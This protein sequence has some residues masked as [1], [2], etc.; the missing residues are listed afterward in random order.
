MYGYTPYAG[1]KEADR[2][3]KKRK[4]LLNLPA[5]IE[6]CR[7]EYPFWLSAG[8]PLRPY[9][10]LRVELSPEH[11]RYFNEQS[12]DWGKLCHQWE[13]R[14]SERSFLRIWHPRGNKESQ[15]PVVDMD[16]TVIQFPEPFVMFPFSLFFYLFFFSIMISMG[17][18]INGKKNKNG[19]E[20]IF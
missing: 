18:W 11:P 13:S 19:F 17:R 3:H 7:L 20:T 15:A 6:A 16:L 12:R 10:H 8:K 2:R 14:G 4:A 5:R 1:T 9:T